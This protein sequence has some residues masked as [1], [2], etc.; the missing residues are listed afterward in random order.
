[1]ERVKHTGGGRDGAEALAQ[2]LEAH[3]NYRV[4]RRLVPRTDFGVKP[5]G[6]VARIVILDTETTG[7]DSK[8]D[9]IIELAL[10][11]VEVDTATGAALRV[12]EVYEAF[13]DPGR[14]IPAD[15]SELTGIT[16]EM[17]R[18]QKLDETHVAKL[19]KDAQLVVAH[20]ARFDRPFVEARL[21]AFARLPWACSI[22]DIDWAAEGWGSSRL[23]FLVM[24]CGWFY[25]AHRAGMDCHALLAVLNAPLPTAGETGLARLLR[26]SRAI[27]FRVFADNAPF[28]TKD[29]LKARG[30][31]WDA[32]RRVWHGEVR[33]E[34]A[35]DGER[36]WLKANVYGGRS[37]T[38]TV[39]K[40][41]ARVRYSTRSGKRTSVKL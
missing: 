4:L 33:D 1:L 3:P 16:D 36:A 23:E 18:G 13:E 21:P 39:E 14:P 32:E 19:V 28:E 34:A 20:N 38:V 37:S 26:A 7:L 22:A 10:L 35:L 41:D 12:A 31:R 25:D 5:L 2:Q 30:Y 17:V 8:A 27:S 40:Q 6:P 15:V 29:Q 11:V 9:K 24:K